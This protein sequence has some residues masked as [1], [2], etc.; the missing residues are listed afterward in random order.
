MR[1]MIWFTFKWVI[2]VHLKKCR[3]RYGRILGF[4]ISLSCLLG[5]GLLKLRSL[6]S[7]L[8]NFSILQK[9]Y[10][11]FFKSHPYSTDVTAAKLRRHLPNMNV[12]SYINQSCNPH[13]WTAGFDILSECWTSQKMYAHFH[14]L[15]LFC[16]VAAWYWSL[17][18]HPYHINSSPPGQNGRH[19]KD[20][21]YKCIFLNVW[22]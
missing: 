15:V 3:V 8:G 9:S 16:F 22:I 11:R 6:I 13:P 12:I 2:C 21:V 18:S 19:L 4:V 7:P 20:D 17:L 5:W 14:I 1:D 10:V